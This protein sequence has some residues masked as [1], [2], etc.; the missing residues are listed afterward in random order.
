MNAVTP[1]DH[2]REL[3]LPGFRSN[4]FAQRQHVRDQKISGPS[5]LDREGGVDDIAAGQA[6]MKPAAGRRSDVLRNIGRKR[7]D[8]MIESA[9]Q[10]LAAFDGKSRFAFHLGQILFWHQTVRGQGFGG[11]Q[12]N[13]EPDF[14]LA[15]LRPEI[16]HF[17]A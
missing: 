10:L 14:E 1:A 13:L 11:L 3:V 6:K 7:D 16:A 5:H 15:L 8:I 17:R 12:F 2:R 4:D 9:L